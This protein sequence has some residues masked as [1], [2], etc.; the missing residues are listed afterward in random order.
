M[1]IG[2]NEEGERVMWGLIMCRYL[3]G[4]GVLRR[5]KMGAAVISLY[6]TGEELTYQRR[7]EGGTQTVEG[8][9]VTTMRHVHKTW[10][11]VEGMIVEGMVVEGMVVEGMVVEG[12]VVEG[13]VVEGMVVE[14]MGVV[15]TATTSKEHFNKS[16]WNIAFCLKC[17]SRTMYTCTT[18]SDRRALPSKLFTTF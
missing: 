14:D 6:R 12:M 1:G 17:T 16:D 15:T 8:A 10:T 3:A 7:E 9:G 5:H 4:E 11:A 13:M 18:P 2:D